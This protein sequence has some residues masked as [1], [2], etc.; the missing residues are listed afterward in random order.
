MVIAY[1]D[2]NKNITVISNGRLI[3]YH[4]SKKGQK[5]ANASSNNIN[6]KF[7]I[8]AAD[9]NLNKI[10][11]AYHSDAVNALVFAKRY[12]Y[13]LISG[14][15]DKSIIIWYLNK[16]LS[17]N[18]KRLLTT[19][20]EVTDLQ[21]SLND[22]FL[23]SSFMDNSIGIYYTHFQDNGNPELIS[24]I[25]VHNNIVTSLALDNFTFENQMNKINLRCASYVRA[26]KN[27]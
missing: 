16:D 9:P 3:E 12:H 5:E 20:S 19:N 25:N 8:L 17:Q 15:S 1:G 2:G 27:F 18:K 11:L 4:K 21:L 10:E 7:T 26:K 24:V 22:Q 6:S 23:F 13:N 14:S